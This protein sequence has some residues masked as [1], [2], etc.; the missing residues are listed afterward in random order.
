MRS[1]P[2]FAPS[3]SAPDQGNRAADMMLLCAQRHSLADRSRVGEVSG[4]LIVPNGELFPVLVA[5]E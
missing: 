5:L 1:G 2:S 4:E 3:V